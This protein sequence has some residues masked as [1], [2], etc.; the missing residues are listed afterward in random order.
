[1]TAFGETAGRVAVAALATATLAS[2]AWAGVVTPG[3]ML[4]AGAPALAVVAG[5]YLLIRRLRRR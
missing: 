5:G 2:P 1:M 4:G 3:P